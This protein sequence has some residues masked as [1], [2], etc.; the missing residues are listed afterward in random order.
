MG[1]QRC[2]NEVHIWFLTLSVVKM[3]FV[4]L[5]FSDLKFF[6]RL[7]GGASGS[8]YRANWKSRDKIVAVKKLLSL[9]KEVWSKVIDYKTGLFY[10]TFMGI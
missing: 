2:H 8:V 1:R 7:G 6:E 3:S 10:S 5:D 4:R 9:D